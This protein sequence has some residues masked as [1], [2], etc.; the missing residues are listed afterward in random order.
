MTR[1]K[2]KLTKEERTDLERHCYL[3]Q[4]E[5]KRINKIDFAKFTKQED[6]DYWMKKRVQIGLKLNECEQ[7]LLNDLKLK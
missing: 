4:E 6:A 2:I 3:L 1:G 5:L 7:N